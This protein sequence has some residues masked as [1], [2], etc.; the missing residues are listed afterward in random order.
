MDLMWKSFA[1]K[2]E[3]S[4]FQISV[5]GIVG[6]LTYGEISLGFIPMCFI[7]L[8]NPIED[9]IAISLICLVHQMDNVHIYR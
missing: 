4:N 1:S 5:K 6:R 8:T 3:K 9:F 2:E 7:L